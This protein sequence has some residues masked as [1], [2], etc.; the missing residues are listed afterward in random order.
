MKKFLVV[1][2]LTALV[3]ASGAVVYAEVENGLGGKFK[4]EGYAEY[5]NFTGSEINNS[6][7]GGGVLAR[8]LLLDWF[9]IQT[10]FSFYDDVE[11]EELGGDLTFSNWRFSAI[12]HTYIPLI[13]DKL[14]VYGGGGVGVQ[15]NDDIGDVG[16]DDALTGNVLVGAGYDITEI[17]TVEAEIGYQF[18]N[19]D[20]SNFGGDIGLEAVFVRLGGGI[21]F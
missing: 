16:I 19:A 6:A 12:L 21:R 4:L 9:G 13:S 7:F 17:I 1:F 20:T 15:F 2:V 5:I 10:N 18:G 3:I 8:Y 11:A 14:Y